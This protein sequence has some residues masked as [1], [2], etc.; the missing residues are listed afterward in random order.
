MKFMFKIYISFLILLFLNN[1]TSPGTAFLGPIFT[2]AKTGSAYQA[3]LSYGSN[4]IIRNFHKKSK[5]ILKDNLH[6]HHK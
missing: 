4:Q 3:S 5:V 6:I 1:C 2:A